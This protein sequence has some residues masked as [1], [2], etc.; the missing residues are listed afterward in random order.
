VQTAKYTGTPK[1]T[2]TLNQDVSN[3]AT[4]KKDW[5]MSNVSSMVEI[6]L[7]IT[8]DAWS[9]RTYK[10]KHTHVSVQRYTLLPHKSNKL[11]TLNQE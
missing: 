1:T 6:I 8:R 11:Y 2:A 3:A 4:E 9:T 10:R 7:Q 5:V